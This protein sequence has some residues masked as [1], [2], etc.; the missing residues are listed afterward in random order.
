MNLLAAATTP[1]QPPA[2]QNPTNQNPGYQGQAYQNQ[3]YQN[4][5]MQPDRPV[6]K[7]SLAAKALVY[8]NLMFN[9]IV[10][11]FIVVLVFRFVKACEKIASGL[12]KGIVIRKDD[13]TT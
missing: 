2:Y 7:P 3:G 9:Y 1:A 13:T 10:I 4:T 12:D 8:G 11:I 5:T 6:Q